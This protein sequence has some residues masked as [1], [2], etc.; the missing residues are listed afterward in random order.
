MRPAVAYAHAIDDDR[1][2][3]AVKHFVRSRNLLF[4]AGGDR[5]HLE[6]RAGLVDVADGAVFQGLVLNFLSNIRIECGPVGERQNLAGVRIFH[7][8]RAGDGVGLFHPALQFPFGNVLNVLID[9]EDN[10][11]AGFRLLFD[12]GKPALARVDGNHQLAGLALELLVE[13]SLQ[14]AQPLIV[15]ANVAQNLRRQFALGI[16]ALGFFLVVDALQI[17][18]PDALNRFRIGLACHPAKGLVGA[19]V[20]QHDARILLSDARNQADGISEI[21]GFRGHHERRVHLDGHRQ[22]T[23]SAIVD[24]AALR[25][26]IETALLLMMRTAFEISV[27]ENL[28]IDQA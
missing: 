1:S 19:A 9:G 23:P 16:K 4:Q 12:T 14:A 11:V 28:Q 5:H 2:H 10:A 6:G 22:L 24:N 27:A 15:G 20:G 3:L 13:L 18:R 26:E 25:R 17:Q 7:D 8:R 21:G